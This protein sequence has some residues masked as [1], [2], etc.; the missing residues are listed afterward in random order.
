MS[1][2]P[3]QTVEFDDGELNALE[4]LFRWIREGQHDPDRQPIYIGQP[5]LGA[6]VK[7]ILTAYEK[8]VAERGRRLRDLKS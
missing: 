8:S 6:A 1:S 2:H 7:K 5:D 4:A 3:S